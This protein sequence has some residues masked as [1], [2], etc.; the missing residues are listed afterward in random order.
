MRI[1]SAPR[2]RR[3]SAGVRSRSP[4]ST[5]LQ[6]EGQ[7]WR[8][9]CT[10][11]R[12][13]RGPA[14]GAPGY[15][16]VCAPRTLAPAPPRPRRRVLLDACTSVHL[17]LL[18]LT[19]VPLQRS[20]RRGAARLRL[21]A[22][23]SEHQDARACQAH[24]RRVPPKCGEVWTTQRLMFAPPQARMLWTRRSRISAQTC[25]TASLTSKVRRGCCQRRCLV[26]LDASLAHSRHPC[27]LK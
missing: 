24:G 18:P 25:C 20:V 3:L 10:S 26:L 12:E 21:R 13:R 9:V 7:A 8:G 22:A 6:R 23:A 17:V 5:A 16:M 4:V 19:G 14:R 1:S 2:A 27:R 11:G 15:T